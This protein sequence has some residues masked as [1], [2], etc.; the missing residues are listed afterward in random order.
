LRTVPANHGRAPIALA[1]SAPPS[2]AR[3]RRFFS[4]VLRYGGELHMIRPMR[5]SLNRFSTKLPIFSHR[6]ST[7]MIM[8][9]GWNVHMRTTTIMLALALSTGLVCSSA[10]AMPVLSLKVANPLLQSVDYTCGDG[11]HFTNQGCV[12][13]EK[14][15]PAAVKEKPKVKSKPKAKAHVNNAKPKPRSKHVRHRPAAHQ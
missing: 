1:S 15:A 8:S 9:T 14:P 11:M 10:E 12:A 2:Q 13:D 7:R 6:H 4:P 5:A 3:L